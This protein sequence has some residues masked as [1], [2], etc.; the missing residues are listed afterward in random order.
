MNTWPLQEAELLLKRFEYSV[1]SKGYIL[2]ET[3]YGPSGLP[4]I[5]TFAEVARTS[6][7]IKAFKRISK[8]P[9]KLLC[10]SDD[11]D[12]LRKVPDNIPN[13]EK[14]KQYIGRPLTSIPDPY[15]EYSSYG[16]YM[17]SRLKKFLDHF[18]FSYEFISAT[19]YYQ[20]G[21]FNKYL[22]KVLNKYNDIVNIM[23]PTLGN[24]RQKTY[25][26]FLP[27]CEKTGQVLQAKVIDQDLKLNT[28]T[29]INQDNE[30]VTT[31]IL[32]GKCKLQW[33]VDFA[34][35]WAA[36]DVDYEIYG[37][38]IQA[39]AKIY[40]KLCKLLDKQPPNQMFYE[41]FLDVDG[42]KISKSRGNGLTID[43]WLKYGSKES[44]QF[45]MYQSPKKAKKLC[46]HS[47]PK[48]FDE[49]LYTI[50]SF[51][52][53]NSDKKKLFNNPLYYIENIEVPVI[54]LGK[55]NFSL[56]LNLVSVCNSAD[57]RLLWS[58]ITNL[59]P[60]LDQPSYNFIDL[61]LNYVIN[62][63]QDFIK[64]TRQYKIPNKYEVQLLND[65]LHALK[66]V[67]NNAEDIQNTVYSIS[68]KHNIPLHQWFQLLYVTLLGST[69][70]P[71]IGTFFMLYGLEKVKKLL[72]NKIALFH[73]ESKNN[74]FN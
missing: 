17:N 7:V 9:T 53:Q 25:S 37:K 48:I 66:T 72:C 71:R 28:I 13:K 34:M 24:V 57:K 64:L 60:N 16:E 29:Y 5:G 45:F 54:N 52:Q 11:M 10:I 59:N 51:H 26:P 39:N 61:I 1:P 55:I 27:I 12:G 67:N 36:F 73:E 74:R 31:S 21:Q 63:F 35:R 42:Q 4:H 19:K 49:Y 6:M 46:Y 38:D 2:F 68:T 15:G 3:G 50:I 40:N 22:I 18:N 8:I 30:E 69:K 32:D 33:K 70:G 58:Y 23:L 14:Y 56:L 41:L 62:Y 44:L 20:S 65:L 43:Q 47:L